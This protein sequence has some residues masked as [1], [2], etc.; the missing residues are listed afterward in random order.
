[1][2]F[3]YLS[4]LLSG[5]VYMLVEFIQFKIKMPLRYVI[6]ILAIIPV[7]I[8]LYFTPGHLLGIN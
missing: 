6:G 1:M 7:V 8:I 2:I 4:I 5:T 3:T